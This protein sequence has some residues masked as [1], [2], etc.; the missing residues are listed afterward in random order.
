MSLSRN[1]VGAEQPCRG[2]ERI[3]FSGGEYLRLFKNKINLSLAFQFVGR[4]I[5]VVVVDC[6]T[7]SAFCD[8]AVPPVDVCHIPPGRP[9]EERLSSAKPAA[10]RPRQTPPESK[11]LRPKGKERTDQIKTTLL[12]VSFLRFLQFYKL[13]L[14]H[15]QSRKT[16]K[17]EKT[18]R[19]VVSRGR[20]EPLVP[21]PPL[22]PFPPNRLA[23]TL[24]GCN[25]WSITSRRKTTP[26]PTTP[27]HHLSFPLLSFSLALPIPIS[28]L[29]SS[30]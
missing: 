9:Q 6:Y 13:S 30:P 12:S 22:R 1:F 14:F 23:P 2:R 7:R 17:R 26:D 11:T 25:R 18:S 8:T 10:L 20:D 24:S 4:E 29:P 27:V 19:V 5:V 21:L 15:T 16:K 28:P 3:G